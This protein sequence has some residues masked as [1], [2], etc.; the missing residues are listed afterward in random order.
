MLNWAAVLA[1]AE[2]PG[3]ALTSADGSMMAAADEGGIVATAAA[4]AAH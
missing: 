1:C 2:Q 4:S 3:V